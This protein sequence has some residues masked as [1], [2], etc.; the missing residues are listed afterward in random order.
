MVED[1]VPLPDLLRPLFAQKQ[2]YQHRS[3][4]YQDTIVEDMKWPHTSRF[5]SSC[6]VTTASSRKL[7][8]S[9]M[10]RRFTACQRFVERTAPGVIVISSRARPKSARR[11]KRRFGISG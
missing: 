5:R 2:S 8:G 7:G 1:F 4:M 10:S 6:S 11:S 9:L 3:L